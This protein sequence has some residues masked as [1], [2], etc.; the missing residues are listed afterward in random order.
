MSKASREQSRWKRAVVHLESASDSQALDEQLA[1]EAALKGSLKDGEIS[2]EQ[3][4]E[5]ICRLGR[6]LRGRGTA[7]FLTDQDVH[8]LLT[9][10]HV[11]HDGV[12]AQRREEQ[13]RRER[14]GVDRNAGDS[15]C[16]PIYHVPTLDDIKRG[17]KGDPNSLLMNLG[18]GSGATRCYTFSPADLDLAVVSLRSMYSHFA[19]RLLQLGYQPIRLSDIASEGPDPDGDGVFTVGFPAAIST[20]LRRELKTNER[21]WASDA[22][23]LPAITTGCVATDHADLHFF[24]C[25]M[26]VYPGN[27]GGPVVQSGKLIGIIS[28]QPALRTEIVRTDGTTVAGVT[29]VARIPFATAIKSKHILRLLHEQ[30]EK[31]LRAAQ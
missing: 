12:E 8:F 28:N 30:K 9:A 20:P 10:R 3:F 4:A 25:D 5:Q 15:I 19:D 11:L 21:P 1:R 18:A 2:Q 31:D 17:W 7:V 27:S 6:D 29:A 16:S 14:D 23:C 22:I 26:S 13:A 24:T